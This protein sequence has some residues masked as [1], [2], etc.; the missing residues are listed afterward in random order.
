MVPVLNLAWSGYM[1]AILR[2]VMKHNP[3][4]LPAWDDL[5]RKFR[6]GLTIFGAGV[7]YALPILI[8]LFLPLSISL[9]NSL[10]SEN[11]SVRD[12]GQ[13]FRGAEGALFFGLVCVLVLYGM[14]L[15]ILYPAILVIFARE[16]TFTSCFMLNEAFALITKNA[17]AFFAAWGLSLAASLGVGLIVGFVN[18]VVGWVPC[19]GWIV[20][21]VLSLGSGIYTTVLYAHLFGQFGRIAQERR[22]LARMT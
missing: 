15:S 18:L 19:V 17:A 21:L 16:G 5:E 10:F 14:V 13:A 6:D 11:N 12:F 20:G 4:P 1:V 8:G 2:N 22:Q 7:I 3:E 9:I